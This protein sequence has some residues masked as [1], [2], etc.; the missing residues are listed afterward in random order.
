MPPFRQLINGMLPKV[1]FPEPPSCVPLFPPRS[2]ARS[3][4]CSA[5]WPPPVGVWPST[6]Y[7]RTR[8]TVFPLRRV[9]GL[10]APMASSKLATSPMLV[11]SRPS[12]TRCT[13]SPSSARSA[14]TTK[15]T[16]RPSVG[17]ASAVSRALS[18]SFSPLMGMTKVRRGGRRCADPRPARTWEARRPRDGRSRSRVPSLASRRWCPRLPP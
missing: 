8:M 16:P 15:S 6:P 13:I 3:S 1:D 7:G 9:V 18:W 4:D 17:R 2:A 10:R 11:R 14:S 12:R 5:R